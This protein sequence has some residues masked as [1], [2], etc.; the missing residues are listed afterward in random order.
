MAE[1]YGGLNQFQLKFALTRCS[2]RAF[3]EVLIV[4]RDRI[5]GEI[6]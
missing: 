3:L 4:T 5:Y 1:I 6:Y 2:R